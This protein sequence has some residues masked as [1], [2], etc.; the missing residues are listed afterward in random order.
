MIPEDFEAITPMFQI[1]EDGLLGI[2]QVINDL[3]GI[4]EKTSPLRMKALLCGPL[5]ALDVESRQPQPT[6]P[7]LNHEPVPT[8]FDDLNKHVQRYLA[9]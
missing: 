9:R 7:A 4:D 8:A 5:Y 2:T 3:D 1:A 6:R